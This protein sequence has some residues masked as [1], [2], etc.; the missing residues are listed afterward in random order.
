MN[1]G[2]NTMEEAIYNQDC[3]DSVCGALAYAMGIEAP[4]CAGAKN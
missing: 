1:K 2:E 4:A 3:L